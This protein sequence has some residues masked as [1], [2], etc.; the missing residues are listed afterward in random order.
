MLAALW[1]AAGRIAEPPL[2]L[3]LTRRVRLGKESRA[4]LPERRG[5]DLTPRP[6]G[7]LLWVH[8]ASV[9]ET[10]SVLPVL[11]E[12]ARRDA[13]LTLLLTTGTLTSAEIAQARLPAGALHRFVPLDVPRWISRFLDHWR[14]TAACWVESEIWPNTLAAAAARD[15]PLALLNARMSARSFTRWQRAGGFARRQFARFHLIWARSAE[16]AAR[17]AVL[18]G[19]PVSAPGDLKFAAA[20][21]PADAAELAALGA[22]LAATPVLVAA[23]LHPGEDTIIA[24]AHRRLLVAHPTLITVII[25]RHPRR[26]DAM[27]AA[28]AISR[29][30]RADPIRPGTLYLAD[31]LGELGLFYRLARC[32][33]IGGSLVPHGGQNP[34][35]AARLGCPVAIGPHTDNF[36]QAC[37][38]LRDAGAL[39]DVTDAA[40][41]ADW[42]RAMV[43]DP[44][45]HAAAAAAGIRA[46][47]RWAD[48]PEQYAHALLR[49]LP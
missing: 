42:A 21:L 12:L 27:A 26:G 38:V 45:V 5:I 4:R 37:A 14:P 19:H 46:A 13:S 3:M 16:D 20:P 1:S 43:D 18:A 39:T 29:R 33:F 10:I 24:E 23:S 15:I 17:F 34:L 35:E 30:S 49:M 48:L 47:Q 7:R 6:P 25:P 31:T 11:T 28:H 32:A 36:A 41:L 9:G 40:S 2:R 44:T 8:A 22:L